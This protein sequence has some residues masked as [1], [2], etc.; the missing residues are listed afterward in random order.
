MSYG[1]RGHWRYDGADEGRLFR[2]RS[3]QRVGCA[4]ATASRAIAA[5]AA[6]AAFIAVLVLV[7]CGSLYVIG[8]AVGAG[9]HDAGGHP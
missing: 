6:V 4:L 2:H 7:V 8:L 3:W 5:L 9:V 1:G